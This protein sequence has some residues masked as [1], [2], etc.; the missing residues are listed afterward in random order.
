VESLGKDYFPKRMLF[1]GL[2]EQRVVLDEW[3]QGTLRSLPS[4]PSAVQTR[5]LAFLDVST[6]GQMTKGNTAP[7]RQRRPKQGGGVADLMPDT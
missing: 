7:V 2:E 3:L 6:V 5:V 1:K 4:A